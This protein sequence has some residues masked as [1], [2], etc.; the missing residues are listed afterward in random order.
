MNHI[1]GSSSRL[2]TRKGQQ[3]HI[4]LAPHRKGGAHLLFVKM[5][6]QLLPPLPRLHAHPL[7]PTPTPKRALPP[8]EDALILPGH[9]RAVELLVH[10]IGWRGSFS[11]G[12]KGV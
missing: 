4:S 6:G 1:G 11:A 7:G 8:A 9:E 3:W 12:S 5:V 10:C 2:R